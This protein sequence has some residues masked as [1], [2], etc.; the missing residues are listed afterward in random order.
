MHAYL[1]F[2]SE[3]ESEGEIPSSSALRDSS[4]LLLSVTMAIFKPG[5]QKYLKISGFPTKDFENDEKG[6]SPRNV[7][8]NALLSFLKV[9]ASGLQYL[10]TWIS[11]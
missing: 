9:S 4:T 11:R 10:K 2:G 3:S 5:V 6:V 7:Y 8:V 1:P